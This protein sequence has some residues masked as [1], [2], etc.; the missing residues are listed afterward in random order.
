MLLSADEEETRP[1]DDETSFVGWTFVKRVATTGPNALDSLL[2][3]VVVLDDLVVRRDFWHQVCSRH[4]CISEMR[5]DL[6]EAED[7]RVDVAAG[8]ERRNLVFEYSIVDD[9]IVGLEDWQS[10]RN[11]AG[12]L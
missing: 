9:T 8:E 12:P 7:K 5:Y 11:A 3:Q 10:S 4:C 2:V 1:N 6:Q